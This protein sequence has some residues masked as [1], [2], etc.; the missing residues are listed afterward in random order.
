MCILRLPI[1]ESFFDDLPGTSLKQS[2]HKLQD[3]ETSGGQ[4]FDFRQIIGM[5]V[6]DATTIS[7]ESNIS[8]P[9]K[10]RNSCLWPL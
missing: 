7:F 2:L 8:R 6:V 3:P 4:A 1:T 9:R 5:Q 10:F